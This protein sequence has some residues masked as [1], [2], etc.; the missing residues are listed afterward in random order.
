MPRPLHCRE[1]HHFRRRDSRP[2]FSLPL[3]VIIVPQHPRSHSPS[4]HRRPPP[5]AHRTFSSFPVG[6]PPS[7][8]E[9]VLRPVPLG[10]VDWLGG[11]QH[12]HAR[13]GFPIAP[14]VLAHT[15]KYCPRAEWTKCIRLK[16]WQKL[17]PALQ[18]ELGGEAEATLAKVR[19]GTVDVSTAVQDT[20]RSR[21]QFARSWMAPTIRS[22]ERHQR[23]AAHR[24]REQIQLL[25][26]IARTEA[27]LKDFSMLLYMMKTL[28]YVTM[29]SVDCGVFKE[30]EQVRHGR[31]YNSQE[32]RCSP[33]RSPCLSLSLS[34]TFSLSLSLS[35][36]LANFLHFQDSFS[37]GG[38][39]QLHTF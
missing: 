32:S 20:L 4:R 22:R 27:A 30:E 11:P 38:N 9:Q 13:V 31:L 12:D 36:S 15:R 24:S 8:G 34:L 2:H 25:R 39:M 1:P 3:P 23:R 29:S 16:D 14:Q 19:A 10:Q 33:A 5:P 26:T 7:L 21:N 17:A 18:R 6:A 35:L 28:L 37:L